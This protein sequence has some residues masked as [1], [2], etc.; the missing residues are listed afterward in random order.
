MQCLLLKM[1]EESA[2]TVLFVTHDV[3]EAI[4][5]GDR[6]FILSARPGTIVEDVPI[7]FSRP[8]DPAIKQAKEFQELVQYVLACLRRAPGSG[9][10]RVSV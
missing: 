10:V 5:L 9:H 2:S 8:R 7:P 1:W 4:F 6:L 3:E